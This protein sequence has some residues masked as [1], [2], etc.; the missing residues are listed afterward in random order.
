VRP[1]DPR[2][3]LERTGRLALGAGAIAAVP[4]LAAAAGT[5]AGRPLRELAREIDGS[6]VTPA[7]AV[8]SKGKVLYNTRF[9]LDARSFFTFAQAVPPRL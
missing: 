9:D 7:S 2:E 3:L 8:Y 4:G 1:L 6:V 5:A